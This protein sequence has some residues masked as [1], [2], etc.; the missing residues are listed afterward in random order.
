MKKHLDIVI[1]GAL[2]IVVGLFVIQSQLNRV[3]SSAKLAMT[4]AHLSSI[5]KAMQAY[6]SQSDAL[7]PDLATLAQQQDFSASLLT[8]PFDH[9]GEQSFRYRPAGFTHASLDQH[10]LAYCT[11]DIPGTV[12]SA[13]GERMPGQVPVI[14]A[15]FSVGGITKQVRKALTPLPVDG[16]SS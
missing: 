11:S 7:P 14:Y 9:Q 10:I 13:D 2:I 16:D 3:S 5:A 15:D 4:F 6:Q 1:V 8:S 12:V